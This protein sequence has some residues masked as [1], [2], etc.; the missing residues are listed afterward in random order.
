MNENVKDLNDEN[1][2]TST[3]HILLTCI[4]A[5]ALFK[6]PDLHPHCVRL[7]DSCC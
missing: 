4:R 1:I 5:D 6:R 7:L 2:K 3:L